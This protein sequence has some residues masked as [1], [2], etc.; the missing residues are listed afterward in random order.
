MLT[1]LACVH[2]RPPRIDP[3]VMPVL[4]APR[5]DVYTRGVDRPNDPLV[6]TVV[7]GMRWTETLSGAAA[8]GALAMIGGE[9]LDLCK[10]RWYA[11]LAGY[12]YPVLGWLTLAVPKGE[13]PEKLLEAARAR[14]GKDIG[15]IRARAGEQDRWVLIVGDPG[16]MFPALARELELGSSVSLGP[17]AW[18]ASDPYG[19]PRQVAETLRLD[20]PGEWMIGQGATSFPVYVGESP[21]ERP[22]MVCAVGAGTAEERAEA[23]I[24][25][26]R[27]TYAYE[28]MK[29]DGAL[30]SVA[31]VR[32]REELAGGEKHDAA[33]QLRAAGYVNVPVAAAT[34]RANTVEACLA[35][36]W[37]SPAERAVIVGDLVE[38]GVASAVVG[39]QV[40]MV[41]VGAG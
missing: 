18:T 41:V 24:N 22:P 33:E 39:E 20:V 8:A 11:V 29:R 2:T 28:P 14:S 31:R 30:D 26:M 6:A 21:P 17:G 16:P 27:T 9:T 7:D 3:D 13:L 19:E 10:V 40:V 38:Y 4:P 32:L 15:L 12:P 1:L 23:T 37:A 34:C 5:G 35:D 36:I 25:T